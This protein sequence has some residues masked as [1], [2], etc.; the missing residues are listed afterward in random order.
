MLCFQFLKRSDL[1]VLQMLSS[2]TQTAWFRG[3][4]L[5]TWPQQKRPFPTDHRRLAHLDCAHSP[6]RSSISAALA[7]FRRAA[8]GANKPPRQPR[9]MPGDL[10]MIHVCSAVAG[11][12]RTLLTMD[13]ELFKARMAGDQSHSKRVGWRSLV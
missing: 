10:R 13:P 12:Q 2:Q 6:H 1:V 5:A 7:C 8:M 11:E 9:R 3:G 4:H